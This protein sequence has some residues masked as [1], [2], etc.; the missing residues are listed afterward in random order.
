MGHSLTFQEMAMTAPG[1]VPQIASRSALETIVRVGVR[2]V[3]G[4][5]VEG[6]GACKRVM[7]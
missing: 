5:G 7:K 3:G 4:V 6:V 2:G 1:T